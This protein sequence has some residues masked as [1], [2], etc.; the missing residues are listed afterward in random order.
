MKLPAILDI[1]HKSYHGDDT[2]LGVPTLS[3]SVAEILTTQSPRHAWLS[4]PKLGGSNGKK[5]SKAMQDGTANHDYLLGGGQEIVIVDAPDWRYRKEPSAGFTVADPG[6]L[7]K[8]IE[9]S[10]KI[11]MLPKEHEEL[12][13]SRVDIREA[14]N[15]RF[16]KQGGWD[17][18]IASM[19]RETTIVWEEE[20]CIWRCRLDLYEPSMGESWDLK[21]TVSADDEAI[22][23]KMRRE[24]S[25][26]QA[27]CYIAA[28]NAFVPQ[29]AGRNLLRFLFIESAGTDCRFGRPSAALVHM[30]EDQ[31]KRAMKK[32]R[33][34]L[35]SGKWP[36][37]PERELI[38]EPASWQLAAALDKELAEG[39]EEPEWLKDV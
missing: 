9:A 10:G 24:N 30:A 17:A 36:G 4:H 26:F 34:C 1:D 15:R 37:Y 29:L 31:R 25:A 19:H 16:E 22:V 28:M 11:A 12:E 14:L 39:G 7:R 18:A 38:V 2:G 20:G 3:R 21:F 27:A 5:A 23:R 8:E 6:S 32:W 35:E 13:S 33:K